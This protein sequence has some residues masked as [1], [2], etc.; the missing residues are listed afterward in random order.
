MEGVNALARLLNILSNGIWEEF[1][2]YFF[3]VAR[4]NIPGDDFHHLLANSPDLQ[5]VAT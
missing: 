3:K 1:V 4:C 2:N 5:K